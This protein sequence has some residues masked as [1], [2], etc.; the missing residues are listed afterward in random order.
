MNSIGNGHICDLIVTIGLIIVAL[1][2]AQHI[3]KLRTGPSNTQYMLHKLAAATQ[4]K[5]TNQWKRT[6]IT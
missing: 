2:S 5:Q 3:L 4:T 1:E 6:P